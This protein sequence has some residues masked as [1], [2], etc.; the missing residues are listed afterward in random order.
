MNN[1]LVES[2]G[3]HARKRNSHEQPKSSNPHKHPKKSLPEVFIDLNHSK[4]QRLTIEDRGL[5][6]R[7]EAAMPSDATRLQESKKNGLKV[8]K[9]KD[10]TAFNQ[11]SKTQGLRT[12][13]ENRNILNDY[14]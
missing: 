4:K 14:R 12:Y 9:R 2:T 5:R 11:M 8:S 10:D 7:V 3:R 6:A 1:S 13:D